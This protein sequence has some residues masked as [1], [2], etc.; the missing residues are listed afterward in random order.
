MTIRPGGWISTSESG[1]VLVA[2]LF[3]IV[4]ALAVFVYSRWRRSQRIHRRGRRWL[5]NF[6][7]RDD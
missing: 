1:I 4:P 6:R 7:K 5:T 3:V 2:S